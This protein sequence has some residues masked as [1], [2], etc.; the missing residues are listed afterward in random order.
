FARGI[1][2]GAVDIEALMP[3]EERETIAGWMREN[4]DKGL[5]DARANFGDRF[6]FGQLRM[7]QAWVKR[8]E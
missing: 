4:A 8:E 5:N 1:A 6:S 7:V 2:E 3:A